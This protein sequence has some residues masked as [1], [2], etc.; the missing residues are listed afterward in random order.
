MTSVILVGNGVVARRWEALIRRSP[1]L[2]LAERVGRGGLEA[3]LGRFP[4]ASVAAAV[5]PRAALEVAERLAQH[6][7]AG[8]VPSPWF[9]GLAQLETA[10][11]HG[12]VQ[13][14]SGWNTLPG[15]RWIS[16]HA[17]GAQ[18]VSLEIG[19]VPGCDAGDLW[20]VL[21]RAVPVIR[22][23]MG[24]GHVTELRPRGT[25]ELELTVGG[26]VHGSVRLRTRGP[27]LSCVVDRAG[28]RWRLDWQPDR[29]TREGGGRREGVRTVPD[30]DVRGLHQLLDPAAAGGDSILQAADDA[31]WMLREV[32]NLR[33]PIS[34]RAL[35]HSTRVRE[36][37]PT[38]LLDALGLRG[39]T[40][41][42][43]APAERI[44]VELPKLPLELAALRAG[45]KPV[46]FLTLKP[47]EERA[48]LDAVPDYAVERRERGV[49]VQ[50]QDRWVDDRSRGEPRVELYI[51][52]DPAAAK[53]A[54]HLQAEGDPSR[55]I[56]ELGALM[57]Y[58]ECC[59]RSFA[60][61]DD[62]SNNSRNRYWSAAGTRGTGPWPWELNNLFVA[63]VPFYPC[64]YQC[65]AALA[66][67]RATLAQAE[68][69]HP[70]LTARVRQVLARPVLYFDH[71]HQV[72]LEPTA[73]LGEAS[74]PVMVGGAA[75]P[76]WTQPA[77]AEFAAAIGAA[78]SL[79]LTDAEL[80]IGPQ[81]LARTDPALGFLA[82]FATVQPGSEHD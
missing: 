14:A 2:E 6:E 38:A 70:G 47:E 71:E 33:L 30:A 41:A 59:V 17:A 16:R 58:P 40:L 51:S 56:A 29:E 66:Y 63:L 82:P 67:A 4:E 34:R 21:T 37:R 69:S 54:A 76:P 32:P 7:R 3:A 62:R 13:V 46:A 15:I 5:P 31:R 50:A 65:T 57:G 45:I 53:K 68:T 25:A 52:S 28:R 39:P 64:S 20:E 44:T 19:G 78:P 27:R 55:S 1:R 79:E 81:T 77:M 60:S 12:S 24:D 9:R 75:V 49:L 35:A 72:I 42:A 10:R 36:Q 48:V 74:E 80:R 61:L 23:L 8:L 18:R 11:A 26:P 22:R 73:D 43:S